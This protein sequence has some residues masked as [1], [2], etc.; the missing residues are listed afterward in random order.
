M[1]SRL[2][3]SPISL[4]APAGPDS[5]PTFES[6]SPVGREV[7]LLPGDRLLRLGEVDLRGVSPLRFFVLFPELAGVAETLEVEIERDG[8]R[9]TVALPTRSRI[10]PAPFLVVSLAFATTALMLLRSAPPSPMIRA[11]FLSFLGAAIFY[12]LPPTGYLSLA[13]SGVSLGL[14][15]PLFLSAMQLFPY[16]SAPASRLAR[17]APWIFLLLGPLHTSRFGFPFPHEPAA[18]AAAIA[19]VAYLVAALVIVTQRYRR[20][21]AL[22]RR[23]LRWFLFGVYLFSLPPITAGLCA[24]VVPA[25][26]PVYIWSLASQGLVPIALYVSVV[27]YNLFDVDRLISATASYNL[28]LALAAGAGLT[29]LPWVSDRLAVSLQLEPHAS[30]IATAVLLVGALLPLDRRL[31]SWIDRTFFPER[32]ALDE[33]FAFLLHALSGCGDAR[34]LMRTLGGQLDGLVA[35]EGIAIYGHEAGTWVSVF[36]RGPLVPPA[37]EVEGPLLATLRAR[38]SPLTVGPSASGRREVH[39]E[40]FQ[41]AVLETLGADVV[42]PIW[43][44]DEPTFLLCLGAKRSGDVYT[45]T[46]LGLLAAVGDK[47]KSEL[48]RY[49]QAEL[50][51]QARLMQEAL[52]RYVPDPIVQELAA[53][54]EV[55]EG[56]KVVSVLFVDLRGY[57]SFAEDLPAEKIFSTVNRYTLEV[58]DAIHEQ[59]GSVVEFNGDGMMAVFGAPRPLAHMEEAA[60][61]AARDIV[62]RVAK[63]GVDDSARPLS[64]GVGIATGEAYLGSLRS[65]DRLIWSAI[66]NTTNLAARLQVLTRELGASI[67]IDGPTCHSAE[68]WVGDFQAHP[69]TVIRG[70][71]E[72]E[73]V[74]ALPLAE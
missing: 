16:G 32:R 29:V 13:I 10:P 59:G 1:A 44:R 70:R 45:P 23:Q 54:G 41:R 56:K 35:P 25:L 2:V 7:A 62:L 43:R 39:L 27:R 74:Y 24:A 50:I 20:A 28:L 12:A 68:R 73:D 15:V 65:S 26:T 48:E 19:V 31:R 9:R 34:E 36:A 30:G 47:V 37:L 58:S 8:E 64:V 49:D 55:R 60:V 42:V 11:F 57:T 22:G 21:D 3:I 17:A 40:T 69:A 4:G 63:L 5:F 72:P 33:G 61:Q 46:E 71:R 53:H 14:S 18:R 66:G 52:R 67:V 51:R 38:Q 6:R